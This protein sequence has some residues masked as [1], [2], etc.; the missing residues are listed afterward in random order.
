MKNQGKNQSVTRW[1][2]CGKCG[3]MDI[4]VECLFCHQVEAMKYF[5]LLGMRYGDTNIFIQKV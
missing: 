1:Y 5:K 2:G 4:N 3:V